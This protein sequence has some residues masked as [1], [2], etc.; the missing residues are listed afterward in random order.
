MERFAGG[1]VLPPEV[2]RLEIKIS[3]TQNEYSVM[4]TIQDNGVTLQS[5]EGRELDPEEWDTVFT[6]GFSTKSP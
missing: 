6:T 3:L 4:F 2:S 1:K 5:P